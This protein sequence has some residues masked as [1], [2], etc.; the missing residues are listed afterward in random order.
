[1]NPEKSY[2]A[3]LEASRQFAKRQLELSNQQGVQA[4]NIAKLGKEVDE[5]KQKVADQEAVIASLTRQQQKP[6][7]LFWL[8]P[9]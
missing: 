8:F 1:M 6:R 7:W 3:G 9:R 5:L 2:S 4:A